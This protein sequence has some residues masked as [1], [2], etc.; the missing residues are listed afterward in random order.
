MTKLK[1]DEI[2]SKKDVIKLKNKE[3]QIVECI[4]RGGFA[5]V[6]K[7]IHGEES[8][9]I[10]KISKED[11]KWSKHEPFVKQEIDI[12]KK[13]DHPNIVKLHDV[14]MGNDAIYL[15]LEF[16]EEGSLDDYLKNQ[17]Y[18]KEEDV[19]Y[20]FKQIVDGVQYLHSDSIAKNH[21]V[22]YRECDDTCKEHHC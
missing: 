5:T 6:F 4:G 9:A 21:R 7:A 15:I 8:V 10:K 19:Y 14:V 11:A 3:F 12:H 2:E 17:A 20:I 22:G 16:C 13:L 18:C 1:K